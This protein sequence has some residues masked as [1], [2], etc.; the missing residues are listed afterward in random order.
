M[1]AIIFLTS[2]LLENFYEKMWEIYMHPALWDYQPHFTDERP[3]HRPNDPCLVS[4]EMLSA[5]RVYLAGVAPP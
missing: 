2:F 3:R 5:T 1:V 4:G